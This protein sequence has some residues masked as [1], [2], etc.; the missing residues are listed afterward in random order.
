MIRF[1]FHP[2]P[3]PMKVALLLEET[4]LAYEM[5]PVDTRRGAQHTAEFRAINPNAKT[6]AIVDT[7]GDVRVFDSNAILL[8]LAE[9]TGKF[10]PAAPALRGELLSW[11]MFVASGLGPYAGQ[12]V[13]FQRFA[14]E[15]IDYAIERY[16][17]EAKRHYQLIDEQLA[18][19]EFM[20]GQDYTIVD[21]AVWGW[22]NP[23][24]FV[25]GEN[26]LDAY[27]NL[28]RLKAWI[29]ARPA[30]ERARALGTGFTT[31]FDDEARRQ[32][33]KHIKAA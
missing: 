12:A 29:D 2:S 16:V 24:A 7:D 8:Y 18:G 13:H 9:K 26:A 5:I 17:Y 28:K 32:L 21:M 19:R 22:T 31:P 20:L 14:P 6:P 1:Y 3:N 11:L 10:L 15:K 33:F 30:A 23:I 25:L 4:G 27:P